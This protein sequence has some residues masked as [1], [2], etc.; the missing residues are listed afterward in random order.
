MSR[1]RHP[2]DV[3][4]R[5]V[6]QHYHVRAAPG[7]FMFSVPNGGFRRPIEAAILKSTGTVAG[8]P[9][10]VWIKDGRAYLLEIKAEGGRLTD[11]QQQV[12]IKL[13][14]VGA[15]ASHGHGL[16]ECLAWLERHEL[17]VGRRQ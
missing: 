2:E 5:A 13:R 15:V 3:I 16:D 11:T 17:L 1:R 9:D 12:L 14:E 7:V 8:I 10:T 4:Q 6:V